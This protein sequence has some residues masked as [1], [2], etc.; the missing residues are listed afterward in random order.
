MEAIQIQFDPEKVSY[1]KL[2]EVFWRNVD[3]T[4]SAGQ[5]CDRGPQYAKAIFYHTEEQRLLAEESKRQLESSGQLPKPIV[6][7][8]RSASTF[9][10][11]EEYHQDYYQKNPI[12]YRFYRNG[13]G[14]DRRLQSLWGDTDH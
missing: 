5:F 4:D 9:Y 1:S 13:C 6:T 11:A 8:I 14:R 12:R 7:P 3:P 2:L 10:R